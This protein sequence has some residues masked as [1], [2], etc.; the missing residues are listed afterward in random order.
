[1]DPVCQLADRDALVRDA[2][3]GAEE[4]ERK[5]CACIMDDILKGESDVHI[6]Y[7]PTNVR[8]A[9]TELPKRS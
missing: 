1:M 2:G 6:A 5:P 3:Q 7:P 9:D 8:E 4:P